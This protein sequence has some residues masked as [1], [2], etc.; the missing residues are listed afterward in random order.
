MYRNYNYSKDYSGAYKAS[1]RET[2]S[3][4]LY[5]GSYKESIH[6]GKISAHHTLTNEGKIWFLNNQAGI[7]GGDKLNR[8]LLKAPL[9]FFKIKMHNGL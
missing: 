5:Y 2:S 6:Y 4:E 9:L 7:R 3:S 1:L 8:R